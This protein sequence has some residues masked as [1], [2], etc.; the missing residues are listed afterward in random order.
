MQEQ[1]SPGLCWLAMCVS[2]LI[3]RSSF[4]SS[5]AFK[6]GRMKHSRTIAT[7]GVPSLRQPCK[8][9]NRDCV[10][11]R[12]RFKTS[13]A[14][15]YTVLPEP[16]CVCSSIDW[17]TAAGDTVRY[18]NRRCLNK[19]GR[20]KNMEP[21]LRSLVT[22]ACMQ[23]GPRVIV[24]NFQKMPAVV[25]S[26]SSIRHLCFVCCFLLQASSPGHNVRR[27]S[28]GALCKRQESQIR[29]CSRV[30][31]CEFIMA[32]QTDCSVFVLSDLT[33]SSAA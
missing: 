13:P 11:M 32:V 23:L 24:T 15:C 4:R 29:R 12:A 2:S 8:A 7:R 1:C 3:G 18:G 30:E 9:I 14:E 16:L 10:V 26:H 20:E 31:S 17:M 27:C 22:L 33:V 5:A 21:T 6:L 25:A 28:C 19:S